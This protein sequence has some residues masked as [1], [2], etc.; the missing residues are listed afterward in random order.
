MLPAPVQQFIDAEIAANR[1][2][3]TDLRAVIVN[4]TLKRSPEPTH[5]D[6]LIAVAAH[7]LNG[8]GARVDA[9]RTVDTIPPGVYPD[10]REHGWEARRLPR[11]LPHPDRARRHRRPGHPDLAGRPVLD[12]NRGAQSHWT[13]RN[14]VVAAWNMLHAARRLKDDGGIPAHGN[15]TT[16][17][18]LG[19]ATRPNPEYR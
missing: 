5:T 10:M 12:D 13:T 6:G 16:N 14:T 7:V 11:P 3:F 8:A 19:N 1:T 4:G 17:W 15:V 9:F 18:D 2:D